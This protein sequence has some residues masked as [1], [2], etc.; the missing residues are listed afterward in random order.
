MISQ[1]KMTFHMGRQP[2]DKGEWLSI[3]GSG[4]CSTELS[5]TAF[6]LSSFT[7]NIVLT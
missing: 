7:A 6:Y 1:Y 4:R 2:M 5:A 3:L